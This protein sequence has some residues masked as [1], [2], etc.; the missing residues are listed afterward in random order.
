MFLNYLLYIFILIYLFR[1][2]PVRP[3]LIDLDGVPTT[4]SAKPGKSAK[5]AKPTTTPAK[6]SKT[7]AKPAKT[8]AKPTKKPAK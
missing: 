8:P 7:P 4:S 3:M 6:P 2:P 1:T 5:S